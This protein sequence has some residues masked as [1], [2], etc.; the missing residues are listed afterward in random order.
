MTSQR[1][2][3]AN[4]RNAQF[5]TGPRTPEGKARCS[6]NSRK[7]GLWCPIGPDLAQAIAHKTRQIA[8]PGADPERLSR[9]GR[10]ALAQ[11]HVIRARRARR[12]VYAAALDP[13]ETARRLARIDRYEQRAL[14]RR[15]FAIRKLDEPKP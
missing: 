15:K 2:I 13:V 7:H 5:S 10:V 4:R 14:W 3:E 12:E 9:A 6:Q 8:G 11:A 1:R